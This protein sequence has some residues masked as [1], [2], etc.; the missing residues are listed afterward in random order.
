M[1]AARTDKGVHAAGQ[2]CSLKMICEDPEIVDKINQHLPAQIRVW[3][4]VKVTKNYHAKYQC[5]SRIY[6]YILPT[7]V[8]Q[9]ADP[10]QYPNSNIASAEYRETAV[11]DEDGK[12]ETTEI[13]LATKEEME[14]KRAF[15]ASKE[16]LV[17]L[18]N[19]LKEYEGSHNYHNFTL[20]KKFN[21]KSAMRYIKKFW[22]K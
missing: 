7:Y 20:G 15:R 12:Y 13:K 2:V 1:R 11:L 21:D 3:G 16:Q 8:F 22:V 10:S 6:E 5:D 18:Q 17:L 4:Y 14:P 19:I 9:E